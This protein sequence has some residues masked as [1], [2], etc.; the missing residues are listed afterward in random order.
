[1]VEGLVCVLATKES[2]T[3]FKL[4]YGEGGPRLA[5]KLD[6]HGVG[7]HAVDNAFTWLENPKRAQRFADN[8]VKR[9]WPRILDALARR[10]NP[11]LKGLLDGYGY[12]W[13]TDQFEYATDLMF[14][15]RAS[16][17]SLNRELPEHAILGFRNKDIRARLFPGPR[18]PQH[19][20]RVSRLL[21]IL[22]AHALIAKIPRSRSWRVTTQG[23]RLMS[24]AI[25]LFKKHYPQQYALCAA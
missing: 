15:D 2:S 7:Y 25:A 3:S 9:N 16:L 8:F 20:A 13:V 12:Y 22:H 6:R 17:S 18:L 4:V 19:S 21:R 10:V 24:T 1:V 11:L 14:R 23:R 5:R